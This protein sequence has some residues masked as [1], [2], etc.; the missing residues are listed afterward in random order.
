MIEPKGKR[1]E[2][3]AI[4]HKLKRLRLDKGMLQREMGAALEINE[5]T[6]RL[7]ELGLR[8]PNDEIKK[9]ISVYFGLTIDELFF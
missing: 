8:I 6:W 4:G 7:Y 5:A 9:R 3:I 1:K 2:A